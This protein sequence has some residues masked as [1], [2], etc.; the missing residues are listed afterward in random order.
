MI[1]HL[2]RR[3]VAV[4]LGVLAM[5]AGLAACSSNDSGAP[6]TTPAGSASGTTTVE[7]PLADAK[8]AVVE[9]FEAKAVNDY[10]TALS[11]LV[12][13]GRPHRAAGP[14]TSTASRPPVTRPTR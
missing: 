3:S 9:F 7:N 6:S 1:T 10:D 11:R 14:R 4:V 8:S 2:S 5:T 13:R 12:R